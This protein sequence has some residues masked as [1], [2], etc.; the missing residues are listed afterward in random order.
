MEYQVFISFN[1]DQADLAERFSR[2]LEDEGFTVWFAPKAIKG[3]EPWSEAFAEA[4]ANS[5][6]MLLIWS[7]GAS[8]SKYVQTEFLEAIEHGRV[9]I[10]IL[11]DSTR[12]PAVIE[13]NYQAISMIGTNT[14]DFY[15]KIGEI[16][17]RIEEYLPQ[18]HYPP[19]DPP[20]FLPVPA[21]PFYPGS[22]TDPERYGN[23]LASYESFDVYYDYE[24]AKYPVLV[25]EYRIFLEEAEGYLQ[26]AYWT[27]AG[28]TWLERLGVEQPHNWP[29]QDDSKYDRYPVFGV[30]FYEAVAYGKWYTAFRNDGFIYRLPTETEW[31]K[32]ARGGTEL[33]SRY[34]NPLPRRI[35]PWGDHWDRTFANT[36]ESGW[37]EIISVD[38]HPDQA[39]S[40]YG[41]VGMAGNLS[42]W[43]INVP[44]NYPSC[45]IDSSEANARRVQRG[46]NW[47]YTMSDVRCSCR[48]VQPPAERHLTSIRLVRVQGED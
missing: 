3:G 38:M 12:L 31:E 41:I 22:A 7:S 37:K 5:Q 39:S 1:Q 34:A 32:A 20:I 28:W 21:G 33:F 23:E 16:I 40:P 8:N 44:S 47:Q 4:A 2:V 27:E 25:P 13:K 36:Q 48:V 24:F 26:S 10:P 30:S 45:A 15:N 18:A 42:E 14:K 17:E 35:Y 11:R 19:I 6:V 46:G 43:C 9:I 29:Q